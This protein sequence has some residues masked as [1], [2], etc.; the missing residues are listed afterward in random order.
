MNRP[1]QK[2]ANLRLIKTKHCMKMTNRG[3][4]TEHS[5]IKSTKSFDKDVK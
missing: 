4:T 3:T 2:C 1:S 5:P